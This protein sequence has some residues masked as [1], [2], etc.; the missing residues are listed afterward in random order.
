[1]FSSTKIGASVRPRSFKPRISSIMAECFALV[2]L[3]SGALD[4]SLL[5]LPD[6]VRRLDLVPLLD[7]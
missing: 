3:W 7:I 5:S 4:V 1:M 6:L 2:V